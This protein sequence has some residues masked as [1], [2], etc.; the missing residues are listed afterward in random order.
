MTGA[1]KNTWMLLAPVCALVIGVYAYTAYS[2]FVV[3]RSLNAAD[4]YYNLLV[5]GFRAGQLNL[6]TDVPPGL[7]LLVDPYD[8]AANSAYPVH[9]MSYYRGKLYLYFGVTPALVLFWPY[10]AL[11]G[12]YLLHKDAGVIFCVVGFLVSVGLLCALWRRYFAE[13]SI[14]VV[15]TGMLA[16][17]LATGTPSLLARCDIWEVAVSCGYML[18]MLAL[19]AIWCALHKPERRCLWLTMASVAYG[20]AVGARP[21]LLFG[22][23][24]LLVPVVQAWRE[25]QPRRLSGLLA[26]TCPI[27]LIGLGLMLYNALRFD[28]PFEF[29][30]HYQLAGK[31]QVAQQLFSLHYLWFNFRVY[32]LQPARWSGRFP[33]V[34]GIAVPPLPAGFALVETPFGVLTN[35]PLVWLALAVPLARRNRS[36]EAASILRW[37]VTAVA[38]LFG[39]C[40]LTL[41]LFWAAMFRY[42][43]EFLPALVL[44]AVVGILGCER[45]LAPTSESG[46]ADRAVWRRGAR[47]GWGLLLGFSVA[48]N[49]LVPLEHY[50]YTQNELGMELLEAGKPTEAAA[51]FERA[52]RLKPDYA[53][54]HYNLGNAL[55]D[56][57]RMLDAIGHYEQALRITPDYAEAHD[58]LGNAL[59]EL[60][61]MP[62]AI[63]HYEQALR[64]KPDYAKS[65]NNLATVLMESGRMPEAI[66]HWEHAL[67]I[68]PDFAEAHYNLG[69]ALWL[70]GRITEAMEHLQQALRIKPDYAEAHDRLGIA[71][72][73]AGRIPEAMEH[74][75]QALRIKPDYAEAHYNLGIAL[76]LA[77]RIPE[78]I[79]HFEHALRIKP[80]YAEAETNLAWLLATLAPADG[81]DPVRAVTLAE[82]ACEL[83]NNRV[84]AY[85]DTLAAAYAAAGRFN[86]AV[87]TAGKAIELAR[88]AG[89]LQVVSE[90]ETRLEL[91]RAGRAYR[92]PASVTSPH[93]P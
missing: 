60:G 32:F 20:L 5:Q 33:F 24:I 75:Q 35:I 56:S 53:E 41:G 36:A 40:A 42:E 81:G 72:G 31:R 74:L 17:G 79:E 54:A 48:F 39:M 50:P 3:S 12:R 88:S 65:H 37:F 92:A 9:D 67:R 46:Q 8:P 43:V 27:L 80:D 18:T 62:D 87:A 1:M 7:A 21:S 4:S 58:N 89:Q 22:A 69:T 2:G 51:H 68:K 77:G 66:E 82:W 93:D 34:H 84:A 85:L 78:A 57:G 55:M 86:D 29:G 90:I 19:A 44:L 6:K 63:G 83:T 49:L 38:L 16:L 64:I 76:G 13:V 30:V 15:A 45:V 70:A 52:L 47:L 11:T 25:P 61:R 59:R 23:V 26:A 73:Q 28:D 10:V 91:Y 71:L 14:A